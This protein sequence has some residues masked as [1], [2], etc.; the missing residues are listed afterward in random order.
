M[1]RLTGSRDR[2][3]HVPVMLNEV[4][5]GLAVRPGGHYVDATVG[6]GGLMQPP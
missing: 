6:L 5:E 4:I 1:S 3:Q 2:P